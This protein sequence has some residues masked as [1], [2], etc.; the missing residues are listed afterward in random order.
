MKF[1][2]IA[3]LILFTLFSAA[4][5]D[6]VVS[7]KITDDNGEPVSFASIY[8]KNTSKGTSA[9][10]KGEYQLK[11]PKGKLSLIFKAIGYKQV[12]KELDITENTTLNISLTA[13]ILSLKEVTVKANREDP[14]YAIMR[15]A[16]RLR[17]KYLT[18][19]KAFSC[20]SYIKGLSRLKDAPKKF[21][22]NDVQ[23]NL[24]SMG[25]DSGKRGVIYLSESV[26]KYN[27]AHPN[28][29][30]E[31]M[32]SSKVSGNSNGFSFNQATDFFLS[33]YNNLI[34]IQG[35]S[36]SGFISPVAENALLS[37]RYKLVG[38]FFEGDVEINKIA[39]LP[40]RKSDQVFKG[41]IYITENTWRIHSVD[42]TITNDAMVE[43]IDSLNIRQQYIPVG[44]DKWMPATQKYSYS[45][46]MFKFKFSGEY[47][48]VF[49]N[50]NIDPHFSKN[51]F[52]S[53][54]MKVNADA[55][56]KDSTYWLN[57]RP[58]P[59]TTEESRDYVRKDSIK[60]LFESP[61]YLDSIDRKNNKFKPLKALLTG[62]SYNVAKEKKNF[63][64]SSPLFD[65]NY[66]TVEGWIYN[67]KLTYR[68]TFKDT[69]SIVA[70][71]NMRYGFENQK[72][73][74]NAAI[75]YS[76]GQRHQASIGIKGGSEYADFNRNFAAIPAIFNTISTLLAEEN[77][78]KLY[79]R[80]FVTLEGG[81]ELFN[82][83][84][85]AADIDFSD[86]TPLL[87][88]SF[89]KQSDIADKEFTAN[90]PYNKLGNDYAFP[91]NQALSIGATFDIVFAQTY[92]DRPDFK[93]RQ[94]SK[95]PKLQVTYRKGIPGL[96]SS[97]VDYDFLSAKIHDSN[98][99]LGLLGTFRYS[100]G[101]GKFVNAYSKYYMDYKHFAGSQVA[102]NIQGAEGFL[103]LSP[104]EFSTGDYYYEG[105]A[106]H[107]FGGF[108]LSKFP[109]LKKMKLE[110]VIGI[111]YLKTDAIKN[112]SEAYIG[113]Q[114][115][116]IRVNYVFTHEGTTNTSG[117]AISAGF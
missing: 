24:K 23:G 36:R 41:Y 18:E 48:G 26:S 83:V 9:N 94:G 90:D 63:R 15:Q 43:V 112:Y 42:L 65:L 72:F 20:N 89:R 75:N 105:H 3:C 93:I 76:F 68:K 103:M 81:R 117:I 102:L 7:G 8:L 22:G 110:E 44:D 82:G 62:Y 30:Y 108:F 28:H 47:V 107:N 11:I 113:L 49:S 79:K 88:T 61:H 116:G 85:A 1:T 56:Q 91:K 40:R 57:T 17:K 4:A 67:P 92:I 29:I 33:F 16:I 78:L 31:E 95:Y 77:I 114:R 59:L 73:T 46:G 5:Q 39:V 6:I 25:L 53:K 10:Y 74:P 12:L 21:M 27:F 13:E 104:Y 58:M 66:N 38:S 14:A 34:N 111:N 71:L 69:T 80:D 35:L 52:S 98:K 45:G 115:F 37:Y 101:A 60:I 86:R 51:F 55:N 99:K 97:A 54:L 100:A 2:A 87:N 32:I 109:L 106:E 50:Y 19:V 70:R 64:I 96:F 84:Y